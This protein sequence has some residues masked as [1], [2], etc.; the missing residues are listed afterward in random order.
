MGTT[1]RDNVDVPVYIMHFKRYASQVINVIMNK[2][3][4]FAYNFEQHKT[5]H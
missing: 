4:N 2:I 3:V 5:F 1:Q